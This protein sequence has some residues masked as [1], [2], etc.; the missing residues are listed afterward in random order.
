[1]RS[2]LNLIKNLDPKSTNN[3]IIE[4]LWQPPSNFKNTNREVITGLLNRDFMICFASFNLVKPF[5]TLFD[6]NYLRI[7]SLPD[8]EK[9][10]IP[11]QLQ[12][13]YSFCTQTNVLNLG[14]RRQH[15]QGRGLIQYHTKQYLRATELN[16]EATDR[17]S[18]NWYTIPEIKQM[19]LET[20]SK[21]YS[22]SIAHIFLELAEKCD[23]NYQFP[24]SF[25]DVDWQ[26]LPYQTLFIADKRYPALVEIPNHINSELYN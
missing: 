1:M 15:E 3:Q 16:L 4:G 8:S 9:L 5:V 23:P 14:I 2:S 17:L 20:P 26:G 11:V 10:S 12:L 6:T 22:N 18:F 21:S 7:S 13:S 25:C 24:C 19:Q